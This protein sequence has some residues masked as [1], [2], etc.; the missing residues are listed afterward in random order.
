VVILGT[1][2]NAQNEVHSIKGVVHNEFGESLAGV[3][4]NSENGKNL[5]FTDERGKYM[6]VV[7]DGSNHLE[8]SFIGYANK[9][10]TV[11]ETDY[12]DITLN[13]DVSNQS[14]VIQLGY[15]SQLRNEL[16]GAV[17]TVSGD[18]L[19]KSPVA[20]LSM[21][22]DGRLSGLFT[23]E[24]SSELSRTNTNL[25]VRGQ[26]EQPLVI[27]DGIPSFYNI[28]ET[29]D[30]ISPDE[31]KSITVLKDASTEAL[32]GI[33]GSNGV[34]V[35]TTKRGQEGKLKVN[36]RLD[37]S[38]Q[39]VTTK[40]PFIN[41]AEYATLRNEAAANDGNGLNYFYSDQQ[42]A[43]F[44]SGTNP[45]YP[46]TNWYN[47]FMKKFAQ[48][49]RMDVNINGGTDRVKYF[50][51]INMMNQG[52]QFNTD[53]PAY[54]SNEHSTWFNFRS[55]VNVK[56]NS[57]LSGYLDLAGNINNERTPGNLLFSQSIYRNI[58]IIPSA[59][60]GPVTPTYIDPTTKDKIGG[61]VISTNLADS[62]Y[63]LLNRSGY[64]N[65]LVTNIYAHFGLNLDM[66]FLTKGLKAS[67]VVAYLTNSEDILSNTQNYKRVVRTNDLDTLSFTQKGAN[68]NTPLSYSKSS[69]YYYYMSYKG[70]VNYDRNFGLSHVS[71]IGYIFYQNLQT[72]DTS[73]P[74]LLPYK[75]LNTGLEATFD[76]DQKYILR[77]DVGYSGSEAYPPGHRFTTTPAISAGWVASRESFLSNINWLSYLKLRASYGKTAN[78][79]GLNRFAYLDN[80][81]WK[82]GGSIGSL[83]YIVNEGQIGNPIIKPETSIK[84][85][86]GIDLGLFNQLSFSLDVFRER[87]DNMLINAT[88]DIPT[89]QG[90][91]LSNYPTINGGISENMGY[92]FAANYTKAINK[93]LTIFV[94]GFLS[95]AK[96]WVI[97]NAEPLK[98]NDYVYRN[99]QEGF[100]VGQ[101]FG[102]LV[103]YS[104]G[105]GFFN[106]QSEITNSK[107]SYSFGNPRVGDLKYK[108]LNHD[109]II[110]QRDEVP[111]GTGSMPR[112]YYGV[113]GG[114]NF[115]SFDLSFLFQGIGEYK[116][117][118][119]GWGIYGTEYDGIFG[120]LLENAY[121]PTRFQNGAKITAP[122]L[123]LTT[124]TNQQSS[125]Y[126]LYNRAYLRLKNLEI[127][128]TLPNSVAKAIS[129][130]KIR[131]TF[132]AQNL[133]T[134]DKMKSNDYGPEGS[135]GA[136]PV[137]KVYNVGLSLL[138]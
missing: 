100:S 116:T 32:Y 76:Y 127:G 4:I 60:Y 58:F 106:S 105:N 38:I 7:N 101:Q 95:Y 128:Y 29:M 15:S 122:A 41:S 36:V 45:L 121:T 59:I 83:Q 103:D 25:Y 54:N 30:Y 26:S 67:G 94:S 85:N 21:T 23:Q 130:N 91:P 48:M 37:Q 11:G 109:G 3:M 55:N 125:D 18:E 124:T 135:Y 40:P 138:F 71:G 8:F 73:S 112:Y 137:Y 70:L 113:S 98:S 84:Q 118:E 87:M 136:I 61:D 111:L 44:K 86:Y 1:S 114:L 28:D 93:D 10:V 97:Y 27:I 5:A 120:S 96:N 14:E 104:N 133:F 64:T 117:I 77:A 57:Y 46:N 52:S 82:A 31:I 92:D 107:L 110:D 66:S 51:D 80:D 129:A 50:T 74:L 24:T 19:K 49:Q 72:E 53:S 43:N 75:R 35:I 22:F 89:Y 62:P 99:R 20:N 17:S 79:Q 16:T 78:D 134:W 102:Y 88:G 56:I 9:K 108:D 13:P 123:S 126:Y 115:K 69:S 119:N 132:S 42:I 2:L 65:D 81:T 68:T 12:I 33:Q 6:I 34:I 63:G 90:V 131:L 47:L 39:Q